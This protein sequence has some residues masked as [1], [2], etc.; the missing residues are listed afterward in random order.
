MKGENTAKVSHASKSSQN[1]SYRLV[2]SGPGDRTSPQPRETLLGSVLSGGGQK[3]QARPPPAARTAP[4][5]RIQHD[6]TGIRPT[7]HRA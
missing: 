6:P 7:V 1:E 4:V 5:L 2:E 3:G